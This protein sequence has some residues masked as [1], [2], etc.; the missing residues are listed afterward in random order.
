MPRYLHQFSY[1]QESL[2]VMVGKPQDRRAVAEELMAAAGGKLIDMYLSFGDYDGVV[3]A[4]YPSHVDA[5]AV[6]M[7]AGASGAFSQMK[8]T[9]LISMDDSLD[10][11]AKAGEVAGHAGRGLV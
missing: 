9:V 11:M 6:A 2:K 1:S 5:A 3:I 7:A 10:A 4:E 8:T